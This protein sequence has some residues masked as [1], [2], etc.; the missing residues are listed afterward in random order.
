MGGHIY[1]DSELS[2]LPPEAWGN[3]FDADGPFDPENSWL[4]GAS[5]DDQLIAMREWFLGRYCDPAHETPYNGREGGYL[6]I[7]GGPYNPSGELSGRFSKLVDGE[8]IEELANELSRKGGDEWAPVIHYAPDDYDERYDLDHGSPHGPL[9]R[10]RTRIGELRMTLSLQ[11]DA[12]AKQ[13]VVQLVYSALIGVLESFLWETAQHWIEER[14]DV[15][16]RCIE[17]H[18]AFRDQPMKLGNV[19]VEHAKIKE[20]VKGY[21]QTMVWHRWEQVGALYRV[22]LEVRL[23]SVKVFESPLSI[24]HHIVHRSGND[25]GGLPINIVEEDVERLANDVEAFAKATADACFE[26]F[27]G[28]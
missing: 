23:P 17:K 15:L 19:F 5:K 6:Y 24:R 25:M 4:E 21:L 9:Q 3:V 14:E 11:K 2:N 18:P 16:R 22:G 10:L 28:F 13:Q 7:H 8:T 27:V 26:K 12:T 20:T 1:E